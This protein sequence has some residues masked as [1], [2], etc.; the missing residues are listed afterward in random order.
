[1]DILRGR[2]MV[3]NRTPHTVVQKTTL[4]I[5]IIA[6]RSVYCGGY[7]VENEKRVNIRSGIHAILFHY[8][9]L[10]HKICGYTGL[11]HGSE[12]DFAELCLSHGINYVV[13]L[14]FEKQ[15][16]QYP[17]DTN[18]KKLVSSA[19]LVEKINKGKYSPKK[20]MQKKAAIVDASDILIYIVNPLLKKS[21]IVKMAIDKNK[22]VYIINV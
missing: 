2:R 10:G 1:M 18:Y 21:R 16:E 12:E 4:N 15:D 3:R 14:G 7:D 11:Q 5:G 20:Q 17:V 6:P 13:V 9:N 22:V 19:H 8:K